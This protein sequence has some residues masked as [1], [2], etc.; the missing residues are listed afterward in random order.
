MDLK[1]ILDNYNNILVQ[2]EFLRFQLYL[3]CQIDDIYE[4]KNHFNVKY[5]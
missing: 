3:F 2:K 4:T 1:E 5:I